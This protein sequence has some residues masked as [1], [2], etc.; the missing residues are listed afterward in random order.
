MA[1]IH[2]LL[3][4]TRMDQPMGKLARPFEAGLLVEH[5][6]V[7]AVVVDK[8]LLAGKLVAALV[9]LELVLE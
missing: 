2:V 9:E 3:V 7:V 1:C 4:L 8:Q 6:E 5:S